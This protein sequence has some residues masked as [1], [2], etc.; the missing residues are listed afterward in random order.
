MDRRLTFVIPADD[1]EL[2]ET[3]ADVGDRSVGAEIRAAVRSHLGA[4]AHNLQR[5]RGPAG[6]A[7]PRLPA[8]EEPV[9]E[10]A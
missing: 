5:E 7:E 2:L 1:A 6:D 3:L 8:V 9:G 4:A 10:S